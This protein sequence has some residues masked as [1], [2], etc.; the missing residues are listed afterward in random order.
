M[1]FS[2]SLSKKMLRQ[3]NSYK[4]LK[5]H[6]REQNIFFVL[7]KEN[8]LLSKKVIFVFNTIFELDFI[9]QIIYCILFSYFFCSL[10][11]VSGKQNIETMLTVFY[12]YNWQKLNKMNERSYRY[13]SVGSE[14]V[15][16]QIN[17]HILEILLRQ[18]C[19]L[20]FALSRISYMLQSDKAFFQQP[21][22]IFQQITSVHTASRG[23]YKNLLKNFCE[24]SKVFVPSIR[25]VFR[26][27]KSKDC[28]I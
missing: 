4:S 2:M 18:F 12:S 25:N 6:F 16:G 23:S 5:Q 14:F 13:Q 1:F 11:S 10:I 17:S 19:H 3:L 9:M 22:K 20:I 24:S 15:T 27:P 21:Q 8:V 26:Q 7:K 28:I